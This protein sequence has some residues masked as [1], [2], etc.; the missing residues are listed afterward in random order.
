[1]TRCAERAARGVNVR[2]FQPVR[3]LKSPGK[4]SK[5]RSWIVTTPMHGRA[6]GRKQVGVWTRGAGVGRAVDPRAPSAG[7]RGGQEEVRGGDEVGVEA[8][9]PR[10]QADLLVEH[11]GHG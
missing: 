2:Y 9:H 3:L 4:T 8:P 1:M 5:A 7:P 6:S 10:R 11:L